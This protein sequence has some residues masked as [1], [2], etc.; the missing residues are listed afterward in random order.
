M[1]RESALE[2]VGAV[3][4]T[5]SRA[6]IE[7]AIHSFFGSYP[8][9]SMADVERRAALFADDAV[10][11]DPVGAT[12]VAGKEALLG[13]FRSPLEAGIIIQ[14][15][16]DRIVVSGNE[17]ISVTSAS[18]G[19]EGEKPASVKIFHNFALDANGKI[20][21]VRIFFDETCIA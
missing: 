17:A 10:L 20:T 2:Q 11:E 3:R 16:S 18:W 21:R 9:R 7:Q 15:K 4:A 6:A 8:A 1:S 19:K 12:P 5:V 13:F 14:M